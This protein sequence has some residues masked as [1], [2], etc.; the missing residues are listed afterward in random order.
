MYMAGFFPCMMFGIA[1]AAAAMVRAAK[2][3]KAAI[4][5]VLSAA[6]C[7]FLCGV[8][9]PFEFSFPRWTRSPCR[10]WPPGRRWQW[11]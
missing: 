2:N 8:T 10:R 11:R 9:E 7:A 5:I 6:V 1:G 4:G 3:K